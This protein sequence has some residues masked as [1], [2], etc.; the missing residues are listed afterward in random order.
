VNVAVGAPGV[1]DRLAGAGPDDARRPP[2][3]RRV[4]ASHNRNDTLTLGQSLEV[5]QPI[6][7]GE[8]YENVAWLAFVNASDKAVSEV[9]AGPF[10]PCNSVHGHRHTL[11]NGGQ[12][13]SSAAQSLATK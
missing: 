10:D 5:L 12:N 8:L 3:L 2:S 1:I 4:G 9:V 11:A 13:M 6:D 7:F